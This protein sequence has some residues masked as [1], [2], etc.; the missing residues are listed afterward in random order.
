MRREVTQTHGAPHW[1]PVVTG[2]SVMVYLG[3]WLM[4]TISGR[5]SWMLLQG[6]SRIA[7]TL[8]VAR[9]PSCKPMWSNAVAA[10]HLSLIH[11]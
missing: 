7:P 6:V 3:F 10:L 1:E 11:I 2:F 5:M 9:V 4:A 8:A